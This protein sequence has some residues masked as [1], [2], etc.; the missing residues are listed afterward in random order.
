MSVP[1]QPEINNAKNTMKRTLMLCLSM[2]CL[3]SVAEELGDT[4]NLRELTVVATKENSPYRKQP[5]SVSTLGLQTLQAN[6]IWSLKGVSYLVPNFYMPD[7]GSRLTSAI[8]I[9]GI[10]SRINT[11]AVGLYVD[12]VPYHDKS[13]FDFNLCD[14]ER[15]DVLRGPQG[16]I[17]GRNTMG[18]LVKVYTRTPMTYEGTNLNL[19][20]ATKDNHRRASITHYHHPTDKL[21]F[22]AGGYY[23][24]SDGFFRNALTGKKVDDMESGGGR[25]RGIWT[26]GQRWTLDAG[27]NYEY[28]HEGAYPYYYEGQLNPAAETYPERIGQ[29]ANNREDTYRR[30][31]LNASVNAQYQAPKMTLNSVTA[32]QNLHDRMFF[33]QDMLPADIY[34]LTQK[35]RINN[36]NEEVTLKS[37]YWKRWSWVSGANFMYQALKTEAP[38]VFMNDGVQWLGQVVNSS[39]PDLTSAGMGPMSIVLKNTELP[40]GGTFDTPVAGAGLFHQSTVELA[41]GLSLTLGLRLDYEHNEMKYYAP[42]SV[43]FD[44]GINSANPRN[45][46]KLNDL[47]AKPLFDGTVKKD[48]WQLLPKAALKYDLNAHNNIYAT[49]SR[50]SRSGGYNVQMFSDLLQ[51]EMRRTMMNTVVEGTE[52]YLKGLFANVPNIPGFDPQAHIDMIM[53]RI[54]QNMPTIE[55]PDVCTTTVY[56][57]EYSWNYEL[58]THLGTNDNRLQADAA[59]FYIDT[60]DQQIARF[61]ANGLGRMMV[62]AGRSRSYGMELSVRAMPNKHV[63][64]AANYGLTNAEFRDYDDGQG[65]DYTGNQVPFVPQHTVSLDGSYT[66]FFDNAYV[67]SLLLGATYSG[68]GKI[69]WNESNTASEDFYSLLS[70]RVMMNTKW[71]Q[72]EL[73]GR[74]LTQTHYN[75]FY[76]ESMGRGFSQHGKPLQVGIDLRFHF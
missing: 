47:N 71:A 8:Y 55:Q 57:P 66:F 4:V 51:T 24:G 29:I 7:Y 70:A 17:Y 40:M 32:Y 3:T 50:G 46:V 22:S 6:Q 60:R 75:T 20:Y 10:G 65:I 34:T 67:R 73:W 1:L 28:T 15:I 31:M 23:E 68:A 16:T 9:R 19:G 12:D 39:L 72:V 37:N 76:F 59:L 58:G 43:D 30:S 45:S 26:P 63:G 48:Y 52:N 62:N 61:S 44:F 33:D 41:K 13:A 27:V 11:P 2:A 14:I 74:N 49:V 36:I 21:A 69:Y 18:G 35:Q 42:G 25:L 5:L 64:L 53:G 54:N 56:K 38:V